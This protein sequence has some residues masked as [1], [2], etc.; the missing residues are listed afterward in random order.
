MSQ[1]YI[2]RRR[3]AV[4]LVFA[5]LHLV[6]GSL[7]LIGVLC[8]GVLQVMGGSRMFGTGAAAGNVGLQRLQQRIEELP[9]P[10]YTYGELTA[11]LVLDLMLIAAGIGLLG[12]RPWAR[13]LSLVYAV[14]AILNRLAS[15]AYVLAV[16][17][18]G[19]EALLQQEAAGDPQMKAFSSL[20]KTS[21]TVGALVGALFVI[22]PILVL[23]FFNLPSV[24]EA[25]RDEGAPP[26]MPPPE[27]D[28]G[29][30][31]IRRPGATDVTAEPPDPDRD[32]FQPPG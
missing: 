8:S 1:P 15:T 20:M 14:L 21:M 4:V 31:P 22:Y 3:P 26:E 19:V 30:G 24:K 5:I 13:T 25:F 29:W 23:I 6:G 7:D 16:V 9:G 27:E 28:E 12:M 18:P 32:R 2:V 17:A 11:N 10:A